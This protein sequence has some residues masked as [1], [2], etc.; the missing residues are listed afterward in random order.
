[1]IHNT[2]SKSDPRTDLFRNAIEHRATWMGLLIDEAKKRGLTT[3]FAHEAI[4]RCGCF[5][6]AN[7]Y[8]QTDDLTEFAPAFANPDVVGVFEMEL[9]ENNEEHL[10]IDFHYC[11]LVAAWLKCGLPEEDIP[12][13]CDI[14][15]DG[16]R[17]IISG[18]DKFTFD[19]GK[20]IAKGDDVCEIRINK[21]KD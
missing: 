15:M 16:D 7:K 11:P 13:L 21:V 6:G 20:T 9:K 19:L 14:A 4:R 1:M 5:H 12:E 18:F 2:P 10:Y 17:G 8:P 3:E